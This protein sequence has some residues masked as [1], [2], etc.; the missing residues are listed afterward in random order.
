MTY[1]AYS[2]YVPY[3]DSYKNLQGPKKLTASLAEIE[4][5]RLFN[6]SLA[7]ARGRFRGGGG[8]GQVPDKG[9][10][11]SPTPLNLLVVR[12]SI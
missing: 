9:G 4:L 12:I 10:V 2:H 8:R 3:L 7:A 6:I 11:R 5:H 1:L